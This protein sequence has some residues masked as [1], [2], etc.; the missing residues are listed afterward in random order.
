MIFLFVEQ[1]QAVV[2]GLDTSGNVAAVV[3]REIEHASAGG[4]TG[5]NA[6]PLWAVYNREFRRPL[7]RPRLRI[8]RR[9]DSPQALQTK[10]QER[11]EGNSLLGYLQSCEKKR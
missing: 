1:T 4:R 7:C 8:G 11:T 2:G 9:P 6:N 5:T 3:K 10:T